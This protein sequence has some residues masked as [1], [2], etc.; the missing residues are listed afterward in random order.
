MINWPGDTGKAWDT[1]ASPS[2]LCQGSVL[3][4]LGSKTRLVVVY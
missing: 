2:G 4:F 3:G 1:V